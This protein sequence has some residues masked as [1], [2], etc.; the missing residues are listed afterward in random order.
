MM[1]KVNHYDKFAKDSLNLIL[2]ELR[3]NP[4]DV[5]YNNFKTILTFD[6]AS[7]ELRNENK[8]LLSQLVSQLPNNLTIIIKGS[9]DALGT[10]AKNLQLSD[11]RASAVKDY[12]NKISGNK[13]NVIIEKGFD[14]F[15]EITPEGRFLNRAISI[16][17]KNP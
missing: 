7:A 9:A 1:V 14:K 5:N 11:Q 4:I 12:I 2:K 17:I 3:Q 16:E 8:E 13:L 15:I 6:F 10:E